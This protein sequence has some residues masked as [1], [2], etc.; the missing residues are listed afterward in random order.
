M[1]VQ[2]AKATMR[3]EEAF[4][5]SNVRHSPESAVRH[6]DKVRTLNVALA[7]G[8]S[9]ADAAVQSMPDYSP[10]KWHLAYITRFFEKHEGNFLDRAEPAMARPAQRGPRLM[11]THGHAWEWTGSAFMAFSGFRSAPGAIGE[12]NGKFVSGRPVLSGGSCV[13]P[14]G[15]ARATYRNFFYPHQ[16]WQFAGVRLAK[17]L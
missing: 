2:R 3:S 14:R 1:Q 7:D 13:T 11:Q 6:N 5:R 12:Y 15:H 17:D 8:L 9:D 16:R 4:L 10:A